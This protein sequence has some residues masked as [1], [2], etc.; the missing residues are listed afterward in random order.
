MGLL[1]PFS[2]VFFDELAV[3]NAG[4]VP[5]DRPVILAAN[6][7]SGLMDAMMLYAATPRD[8]RAVGKSTLWKIW[9]LRPFLAA[10]RVIPIYRQKDGGGDNAQAFAA[11]TEALVDGGAVGAFAEGVSHDGTRAHSYQCIEPH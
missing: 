9:P 5:L 2:D 10:G 4:V 3:S 6:H 1:W 11:V 7:H 8:L